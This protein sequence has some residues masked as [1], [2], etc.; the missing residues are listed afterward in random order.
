MLTE[1]LS[2]KIVSTTKSDAKAIVAKAT[3]V[4]LPV[5]NG[6]GMIIISVAK[7]LR[8]SMMYSGCAEFNRDRRLCTL[9]TADIRLLRHTLMPFCL[10]RQIFLHYL[11]RKIV[12]TCI[13]LMNIYMYV[14]I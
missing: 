6:S 12:S 11:G 8:R 4:L 3:S 5:L 9:I 14:F 1:S 7:L 2:L 13:F 10:S